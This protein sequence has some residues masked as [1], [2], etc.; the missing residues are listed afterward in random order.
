VI[1]W[2]R[3]VDGE[4]TEAVYDDIVAEVQAAL[5]TEGQVDTLGRSLTWRT[6]KPV[7]GKRRAVQV[8]VTSRGGKTRIHLQ[9]R[10]G[11]LAVTLYSSILVGGGIGGVATILGMGLGWLG[12]GLESVLLSVAW[13]PGMYALTRSI[14]RAVSRNKRTD[15]EELSNHIAEIAAESARDRLDDGQTTR[16]L[17]S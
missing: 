2:E 1:E 9:E 5:S 14:F 11:E 16:A 15:L 6:V 4:V 17:P 13:F 3:V 7:L 12:A 10:L 8:R